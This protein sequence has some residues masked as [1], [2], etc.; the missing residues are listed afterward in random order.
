MFTANYYPYLINSMKWLLLLLKI[1]IYYKLMHV[2]SFAVSSFNRC[3]SYAQEKNNVLQI[4]S[5]SLAAEAHIPPEYVSSTPSYGS[6]FLATVIVPVIGREPDLNSQSHPEASLGHCGHL[7]VSQ[8]MS[9]LCSNKK[10]L[11]TTK[12]H[13]LLYFQEYIYDFFL[14]IKSILS[15]SYDYHRIEIVIAL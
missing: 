15:L 1:L 7:R 13:V 6:K 5:F 3:R 9:A 10:L 14:M 8:W 2:T 12:F 11:K 4:Y